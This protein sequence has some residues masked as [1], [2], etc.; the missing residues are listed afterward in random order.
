[1][2]L[3]FLAIPKNSGGQTINNGRRAVVVSVPGD[4]LDPLADARIAAREA[5]ND[6]AIWARAEGGFLSEDSLG[7]VPGGVIWLD[8][9]AETPEVLEGEPGPEPGE[10]AVILN[11]DT[12]SVRNSAGAN[13]HPATAVVDGTTLTGVNLGSGVAMVDDAQVLEVP[14]TG[15]YT[16]SATVTVVDGVITAI[17][18]A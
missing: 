5:D 17:E 4:A 18:L 14:V 10:G 12:V 2:A 8:V 7:D 1:M 3:Y 9:T 6:N 11:E 16:E 13:A 15:D